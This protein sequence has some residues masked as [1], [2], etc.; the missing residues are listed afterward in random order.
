MIL[1]CAE[2]TKND[3]GLTRLVIL[4]SLS[5]VK[6]RP[7]KNYMKYYRKFILLENSKKENNIYKFSSNTP[8]VHS[9]GL[10]IL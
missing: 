6:P 2:S 4:A 8:G 7:L 5:F 1:I 3:R 10:Q 9:Q